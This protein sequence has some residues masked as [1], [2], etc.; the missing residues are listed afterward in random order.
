MYLGIDLGTSELELLLP[1]RWHQ[2]SVMLSAASCLGW[3]AALT[4]AADVPALLARAA[5]LTAAQRDRAPLFMPYLSGERTPHNDSAA[6]GVLFGL[7]HDHA[8]AHVAWAVLEGV[9]F[10]LSD[11]W[12]SMALADAAASDVPVQALSLVGGGAR[13]DLWAQLLASTL[14]VPLEVRAGN[15]AGGA[16]GAARLG[17]L[18]AGGALAEVCR[19]PGTV[20][21]RFDPDPVG[22]D[23]LQARYQRFRALYPA[24]RGQF[25]G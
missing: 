14:G 20:A 21:R 7:T 25:P 2:M 11:G 6:Q 10:R 12:H 15:E 5:T 18:A 3:A 24:L 22:R 23:R 17:W 19:A 9:G 4:G 13:S 8:A 1:G 16:V